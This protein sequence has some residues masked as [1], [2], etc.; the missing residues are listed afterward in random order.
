MGDGSYTWG[1]HHGMAQTGTCL[2][3]LLSEGVR[4]TESQVKGAGSK[5]HVWKDPTSRFLDVL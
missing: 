5:D 1:V 2:T 3:Y 4:R